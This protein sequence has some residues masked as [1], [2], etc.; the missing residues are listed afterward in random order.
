MGRR[1]ESRRR[2]MVALGSQE[3]EQVQAQG[4]EWSWREEREGGREEGE[5]EERELL[6]RSRL[7]RWGGSED[8]SNW[9][10]RGLFARV[11]AESWV[12]C[13]RASCLTLV[14]EGQWEMLREVR[15]GQ[16]DRVAGP[17]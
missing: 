6:L 3:R 16:E 4:L 7:F 17:N 2:G 8:G 9:E 5:R 12:R 14:R 15:E 13:V 10:R 11:S 1:V